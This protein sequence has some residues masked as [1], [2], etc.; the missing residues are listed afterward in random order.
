[1]ELLKGAAVLV[2]SSVA[3][4]MGPRAVTCRSHRRVAD[5]PRKPWTDEEN[6]EFRRQLLFS[7]V[8]C[9]GV[10]NDT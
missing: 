8:K 5:L 7:G 4:H 9:P 2:Y 10:D 6:R 3:A 1:V